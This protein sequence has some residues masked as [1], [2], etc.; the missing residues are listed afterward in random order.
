M[1]AETGNKNHFWFNALLNGILAWILG[2]ILYMIPGLVLGLQMGFQL[3]PESDDPAAVSEQIATS[4]SEMYQN[5]LW[6][7]IA[8]IVATALLIL[9]R[10][11]EIAKKNLNKK[12]SNGLWVAAFPVLMGILLIF[13]FGFNILSIIEILAFIAAGYGGGYLAK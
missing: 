4:V 6:L 9:W 3:G 10:S 5:S 11:R 1:A 13:S 12:I 2:F 7:S 8:F